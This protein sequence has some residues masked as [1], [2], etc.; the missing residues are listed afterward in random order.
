M[1]DESGIVTVEC[2]V[3]FALVVG[4]GVG[5]D[6]VEDVFIDIDDSGVW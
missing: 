2:G 1:A 5:A 6:F 4:N 3:D